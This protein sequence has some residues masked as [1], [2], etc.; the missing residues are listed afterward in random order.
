MSLSWV[1]VGSG[2]GLLPVHRQAI[3][4]TNAGLLSL[5]PPGTNFSEIRIE[6]QNFSL[7]R[8]AFENV[9]C[10]IGCHFVQG[11]DDLS[12]EAESISLSI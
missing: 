12:E 4:W 8:N 11:G 3:A 5:G 6:M 9:I 10:Q 2:N 7:I 1:S